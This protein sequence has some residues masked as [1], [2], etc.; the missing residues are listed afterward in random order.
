MHVALHATPEPARF[1]YLVITTAVN[2][3]LKVFWYLAGFT[4]L[5]SHSVLRK[6]MMTPELV[7]LIKLHI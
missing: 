5:K 3:M 2:L 6:Q 1:G 7:A 4:M